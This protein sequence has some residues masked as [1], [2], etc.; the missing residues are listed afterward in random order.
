MAI[1]SARTVTVIKHNDVLDKK[2]YFVECCCS[3]ASHSPSVYDYNHTHAI[4]FPII[5]RTMQVHFACRKICM[6]APSLLLVRPVLFPTMIS[7]TYLPLL[8]RVVKKVVDVINLEYQ[9]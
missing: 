7:Q 3:P 8:P 1:L 4:S 6:K 2:L 9:K 5:Y